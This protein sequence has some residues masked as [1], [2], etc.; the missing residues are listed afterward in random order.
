MRSFLLVVTLASLSA[1]A[2]AAKC[3]DSFLPVE[4]KEG[5]EL[6]RALRENYV[7]YEYRIP[8]RDGVTLYTTA[9]VPRDRTRRW[10]MMLTRTPYAV[11]YGV[12]NFPDV[13]DQRAA[14]RFAPS[15]LMVKEGFI[16]VHQDVRGRMMSQG[17]FLDVRPRATKGGVDEATD[18]YDTIDFLVKNVPANN[19]KVGVWGI[20]Y[21]GFYAA[22][23]A[24]D[25]HP[26]LKAVSPQAPVTD[27]FVGD[28][29]HHNG[30]LFLLDAFHF[31]S[32]FGRARA[33]PV[34]RWNWDFDF[35]SADSYDF[36]Q[37]LG[38]LSNANTKYFH[39]SIAF[40]NDVLAHPTRDAWWKARDPLPHY[41]VSNVAVLTVGGLFDAEDLW[42]TLATYQAFA[43]QSPKADV[44]LVMGP[45]RH[46][47]WARTDGDRL[48]DVSFAWKTSRAWVEQLEL[49]F[50][51]HHLKG[52][53]E[54]P[55]AKARVFE[56]GTN[57]FQSY[58]AWPPTDVKPTK[59]FFAA[60]GLSTKAPGE[61]FD[62]YVSDP[63]AP[64]PY[65]DHWALEN[66]GEYMVGD[67]RFASRRPDV[68]THQSA[69]LPADVTVAGP[70]DVSLDVT[71][72]GTDGDF[73]VKLVDVYPFDMPDPDPNPTRV[74]LGGYQQ[75]V[76][77]EVF[78]G[79]FREG[80][81]RAV[82]FVPGQPTTVHF[83]L[84]DVNHTFRSGHRLMLQVQSS[85]FP[86]VDLNPQTL[87]DPS[88]ATP[89][90]FKAATVRVNWP[91]TT[92]TLPVRAGSLPF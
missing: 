91:K 55:V 59:V 22:Q 6:A 25:A 41:R 45:W 11:S 37:Q 3:G 70:I 15:T 5:D 39:G 57:L 40:W 16:F 82:P 58:D 79:H 69:P 67:Q 36:F 72:T 56:T 83:T 73:I 18:T 8:M 51:L 13:H 47:G 75:L 60:G 80:F 48:G 1:A 49:P 46:G 32:V 2:Q 88:T 4:P 43:R 53:P 86:L 90:D 78:R 81:E 23:A 33:E 87:V 64:V 63:R 26:A 71:T 21:P 29:F 74:H 10:P 62:E 24:I 31:H 65:R 50:F 66:D 61:G 68:V 17:Q 30:A 52:C 84:P 76:R 14:A 20:S 7:K 54:G 92:F 38:P 42:G 19:G 89:A 28:D 12:D 35:D 44:R 85:W 77:G 9:F 27:W 34:R